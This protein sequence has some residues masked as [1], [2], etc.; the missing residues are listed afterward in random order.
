VTKTL[1]ML[2][3]LCAGALLARGSTVYSFEFLGTVS[4][5]SFD[6]PP[7]ALASI[8]AGDS[9]RLSFDVDSATH[10]V[11]NIDA[12]FLSKG[13]DLS[14]PGVDTSFTWSTTAPYEYRWD[15]NLPGMSPYA[16]LFWFRTTTA[17]VVVNGVPPTIDVNQFNLLHEA[18]IYFNTGD[19]GPPT[20]NVSLMDTPEPS[21]L[22][23]ATLGVFFLFVFRTR[24]RA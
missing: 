4:G 15:F 21:A 22:G 16:L 11:E 14:Y 12:D 10:K 19:G 23:L 8:G 1:G 2:C 9:F 17:G 5:A 7:P 18:D 13:I 6:T 24:R 3:F 20:I